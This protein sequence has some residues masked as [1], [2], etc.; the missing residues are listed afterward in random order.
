LGMIEGLGLKSGHK[1]LSVYLCCDFPAN[2]AHAADFM[3]R[4]DGLSLDMRKFSG[5]IRSGE[6]LFQGAALGSSDPETAMRKALE[7]MRD[8]CRGQG[9]AFIVRDRMF[10]NDANLMYL[11]VDVGVDAVSIDPEA[12]PKIME[13]IAEAEKQKGDRP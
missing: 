4:F 11:L 9:G 1:G 12:A 7:F 5:W 6:P 8:A 2:A 10:I 3:E 13:W